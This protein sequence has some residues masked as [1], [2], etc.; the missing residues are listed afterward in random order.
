MVS[1][2]YIIASFA[3]KTRSRSNE[4]I[5]EQVLSIQID[6]LCQILDEKDKAGISNLVKQVTIVIPPYNKAN[7]Y[8]K[9]YRK[10]V[11][12]DKFAKYEDV[13]LVFQDYNGRNNHYSYDQWIQ[14]MLKYPQYD[15]HIIIEDDYCVQPGN[16]TFDHDLVR[17]YKE[18]FPDDIGYLCSYA[19][20]HPRN[21]GHLHP[22]VS[23]GMISAKTIQYIEDPLTHY[24]NLRDH[25]QIA[26][27]RLFT[28]N[29]ISLADYRESYLVNFW[30]SDK[31]ILRE[32]NL[33]EKED[34]KYIFVPVQHLDIK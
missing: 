4:E 15:Y 8:P 23:N 3:E 16:L 18:K 5:S 11:W 21:I 12:L 10:D 2:N 29:N 1:I 22:A 20:E 7:S 25:A 13:S 34:H 14:G 9:Y 24:Y 27:G 33:L 26:F 32:F 31:K 30:S 17:V 6:T 19:N 28:E